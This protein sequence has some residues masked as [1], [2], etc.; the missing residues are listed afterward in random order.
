M[1]IEKV[2]VNP[3]MASQLLETMDKNRRPKSARVSL[4]SSAMIN[5]RWKEDTG[6]LIKIS[7]KG[8]LIDGQ[9]RM[10]AVVKSGKSIY[11][12]FAK[13]IDDS[14]FDVLDTGSARSS[15]DV[16]HIKSVKNANVIPSIIAFYTA[17][18]QGLSVKSQIDARM[19]SSELLD[20]YYSRE[21]FWSFTAAKSC[22]WYTQFSKVLA[23]S[24]IG[25]FYSLFYDIS[26]VDA[27]D[28]MNQLCTGQDIS[29]TSILI[30]R[31]RL[32]DDKMSTKRMILSIK[33]AL[34]IK[35][36]NYYRSSSEIKIL[37]F[38]IERDEYPV[39]I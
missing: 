1:K 35:A 21:K 15:A 39:A 34:I 25:G 17:T 10:L 37:K 19:I 31:K 5:G 4:Y 13:E 18:K 22:L 38:D 8:K 26:P 33:C 29:N 2:L 36:W 6:E 23:P 24:I 12:H 16:F 32:I 11:F 30:L 9:H 3:K 28:F 20:A 27:E 14:V 7:K